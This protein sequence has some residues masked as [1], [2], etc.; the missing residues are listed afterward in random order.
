M[1]GYTDLGNPDTQRL[2]LMIA[3]QAI[4]S[5]AGL[6]VALWLPDR[7]GRKWAIF[8]GNVIIVGGALGQTFVTS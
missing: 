6:C 3:S 4:G 5:V 8:V 1:Q 2:S 7:V